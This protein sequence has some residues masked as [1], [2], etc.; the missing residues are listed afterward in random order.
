[1]KEVPAKVEHNNQWV[2]VKLGIGEDRIVIPAPVNREV[3]FKT[4][5]DVAERKN[6]LIVTAK[7]ETEAVYKILSVDKVIEVLKKLILGSCNAYRLMAYFMSPA[8]RGGV[9]IQNAQWEKGS[10]VVVHSGIWFVSPAKQVCVPVNDVAA[11]E[12]TKRDV[13]GKPTDVVRIDHLESGE[14]VS[15]L[16]LCPL[17]TLQVLYNFLKETTKSMDMKGTEL[18]GVDQQV[19]MLIY[20]GMDSH[21]I[22]NMLNLP[23]KQLDAIYDKI[24]KLGLA[25]VVT[26]RREV[27]L[28]T[29]GVR[30]ISDATK[31]Q[32]N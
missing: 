20:S 26:I 22:E 25:E 15:S 5:S 6:I 21:A 31:S 23:H 32:T 30:Y 16:V 28:T 10:V 8:I 4:V 1:M 17:S 2:V 29:K 27:Q 9:L 19:A 13:Q 18:D 11:I 14:V 12:L 24:M 3:L 7:T